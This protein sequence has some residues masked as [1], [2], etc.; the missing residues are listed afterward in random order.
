ML[1]GFFG[2]DANGA[3]RLQIHK[4]GGNFA[5]VAEL[6]R[7][8]A[9]PAVGHD[10]DRIGNAA[11]D[12]NVGNEAFALGDGI[13]DAEFAQAEHRQAH[14]EHLAGTK[15]TMRPGREFQI[16]AER[17]HINLRLFSLSFLNTLKRS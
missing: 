8:F 17:F 5:P 13:V 7:A 4:G 15:M 6:Q 2:G 1:G 12:L 10:R 11:I 14:A 9:E 16:F 3:A